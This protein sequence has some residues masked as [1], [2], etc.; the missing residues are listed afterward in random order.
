MEII[1]LAAGMGSRL[2]NPFPKPL[3]VLKTGKSIMLSQ[4]ENLAAAFPDNRA[5][6]V[7]GF[8]KEMI[9][10]AFPDLVF[11]YNNEFDTTNTSKSL[12]RAL[13]NVNHTGALWLNGDVVFDPAVL[14]K[15]KP[16]INNGR[17]F[18]CVNRS[19]VGEEEV[20]YTIDARG[21]I[22]ELS[23]KV[24]NAL[25]EAVGI[26]YIS[27]KDVK[28][29]LKRLDEC[30]PNDYFERGIEL[31]I[32]KDGLEIVP[33]DISEFTCVEVDFRQDLEKANEL[34]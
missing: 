25:G 7:V 9:M 28:T 18:V 13:R 14:E 30:D 22:R 1:I 6:I 21:F 23:K 24:K 12:F 16:L 11:I 34:L 33:A 10:E 15:I 19:R 4:L 20:K 29:L 5:T 3:T 27:K 8:K 26:N 32:E 31:A 17:S 2:G